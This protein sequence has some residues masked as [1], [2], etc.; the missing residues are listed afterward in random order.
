MIDGG[1]CPEGFDTRVPSLFYETIWNTYKFKDTPG[2][3]VWSNGD[4]TGM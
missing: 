1:S 3:F 2:Q 4:P